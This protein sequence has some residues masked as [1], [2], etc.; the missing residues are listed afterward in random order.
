MSRSRPASNPVSYHKQTK[1]YYLT[2]GGRRTYLGPDKEEALK[3]YHRLGLGLE[4]P[5]K[6]LAPA[7]EISVKELANRF[8]AT[9]QANWRSPK[10]TLKSYKDWLG[11]FIK[12]HPRLKVANFSVEDFADWK[13]SLKRR[14][15]SPESI[16]H[17]LM[18]V[19]VGCSASCSSRFDFD[20]SDLKR[21]QLG[22]SEFPGRAIL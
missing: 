7:V 16:N 17:F 18:A 19:R 6:E 8:I 15:Y 5:R 11:R 21:F 4:L 3:K 9:Q 1:Q 20:D 13:V 22:G 10:E 14:N 12:D 2:R